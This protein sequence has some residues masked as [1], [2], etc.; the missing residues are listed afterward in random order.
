MSDAA[1]DWI[2]P[3]LRNVSLGGNGPGDLSAH[4]WVLNPGPSPSLVVARF[5]D[6][7][8][9]VV[10]DDEQTLS[11]FSCRSFEAP[12]TEQGWCHITSQHPVLPWGFTAFESTRHRGVAN[13]SFHRGDAEI[14]KLHV[15]TT[16]PPHK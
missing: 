1:T 8:G 5:F 16:V 14:L 4:V 13:M 9:A 10:A 7:D 15:P 2:A 12:P 6:V 3:Y 11:P